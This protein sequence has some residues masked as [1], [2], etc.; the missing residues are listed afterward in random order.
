[1]SYIGKTRR[2]FAIQKQEHLKYPEKS[3]FCSHFR[4]FDH[5]PL[6]ASLKVIAQ[7]SNYIRLN[8]RESIEI[9]KFMRQFP[10]T[11]INEQLGPCQGSLIIR[12]NKR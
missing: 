7:E 11:I 10:N 4:N 9:N 6:K 3:N 1:M 8:I 12:L 5:D 2:S